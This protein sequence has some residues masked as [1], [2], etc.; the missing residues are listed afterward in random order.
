MF[1]CFKRGAK[2]EWREGRFFADYDEGKA[3]S[4]LQRHS[5]L[6]PVRIWTLHDST[7]DVLWLNLIARRISD[8]AQR[9]RLGDR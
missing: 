2:E 8:K 6:Q 5:Q 7:R 4:L 9:H 3:A 1:M